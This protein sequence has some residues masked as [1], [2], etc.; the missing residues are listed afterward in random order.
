MRVV[1]VSAVAAGALWA[2][3]AVD[4]SAYS[5]GGPPA[6]SA[7]AGAED[8]S[9]VAPGRD[10][11]AGD[12][13][14]ADGGSGYRAALMADAPIAYWRLGESSGLDAKDEVGAHTGGYQG[15]VTLGVPGVS[16]DG[17]TSLGLAGT[18]G[19]V[20]IGDVLDF[21]GNVSLS[22]EAWI[23][24]DVLDAD[25]RRVLTKRRDE[26]GYS[27]FCHENS[28]GCTVELRGADAAAA[29][30]D[31]ALTT[32]RWYHVVGTYDGATLRAYRD[33]VEVC[34]RPAAIAFSKVDAPLVLGAW[35]TGGNYFKG[36][37]DEIAIYGAALSPARVAA[38]F[39]H[40]RP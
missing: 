30:C 9:S 16:D 7:D 35:P 6:E 36:K 25:Y 33:S 5:S 22:L 32:G 3:S 27:I 10:A 40:G 31:V 13:G 17:D 34:S 29:F 8:G 21:E 23:S 26:T 28:G 18:N 14:A 20:R 2:C 39:A 38:H 12:A 11:E 15:A 1:V 19:S 24:V 37:L 4:L